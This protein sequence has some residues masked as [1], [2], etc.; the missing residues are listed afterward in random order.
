[1]TTTETSKMALRSIW[2]R[3]GR[4]L[5]TGLNVLASLLLLGAAVAM[6]NYLSRNYFR[7]W[8][9]TSRDY[10]RLSDKTTGLLASLKD[11]VDVVAFFQRNDDLFEDV[12]N[13]LKEYEYEAAGSGPRRL[14]IEIVDPDRDLARTRELA[15]EYAVANANVVVF[16]CAGRKKYVERKDLA[17]YHYAL[18]EGRSVKKRKVGFKGEQAFSSAIQS[19]AQETKPVIYFLSGHG[20][21]SVSNFGELNGYSSLARAMGRDNIEV[22]TLLMAEHKGVPEDCSAIVIAGA[23]R[24][25]SRAEV[26]MLE[27]YL[28]RSG[29]LLVLLEPVVKTGLEDLLTKWGVKLARD[30]VMGLT[31]TGRDLVVKDY[32]S[33]DITR[34]LKG[35]TAMFY[36]PRSVE[37]LDPVEKVSDLP[38]DRPHV[39]VL[40]ITTPE[41][42]AEYDL[43]ESPPRFDPDVDRRG[44]VS[45]AV[46]VEKGPVPGIDVEIRPT[47][48]VVLGDCDFVSN[49]ALASGVGGNMDV[50]LSSINWLIEREA[51]LAISPKAPGEL[52][53]EMSRRQWRSAFVAIVVGMP[54]AVAFLGLM[55]RL[56]RKR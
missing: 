35:I 56:V 2:R 34:Q 28:D 6:V 11:P 53:M 9:V 19:V 54:L 46:A 47:R 26:D 36:L 7:R 39:S 3:R 14:N 29:R 25:L 24:S 31:L 44:P 1:M 17:D 49:S 32:G 10:Y 42:W 43:A 4:R 8:D 27:N 15:K 16:H 30:V 51:L 13:L 20:E 55:V 22:K 40:A 33:H 23:D 50:F 38:A 12:R 48:M 52:R 21:R 41:G 18:K 5:A 45:V 37:P